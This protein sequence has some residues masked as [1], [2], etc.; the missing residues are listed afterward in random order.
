MLFCIRGCVFE[1]VFISVGFGEC[2]CIVS[3]FRGCLVFCVFFVFL[4]L[5]FIMKVL[6]LVC[7]CYEVVCCLL[8]CSFVIVWGCGKGLVVEELLSLLDD[9]NY[10]YLC[11]RELVFGVL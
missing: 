6:S 7:G 10:C 9:M 4:I 8:E 2:V 3:C 1:V 11:L 5:I